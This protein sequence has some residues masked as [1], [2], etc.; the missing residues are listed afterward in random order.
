MPL[1][2]DV[3]VHPEHSAGPLSYEIE[4]SW[5][6]RFGFALAR[7]GRSVL[8]QVHTHA[9]EAFHSLTDDRWPIV[10]TPGFLSLVL[11]HFALHRL[12][13]RSMYL[14][15]IEADGRFVE[16]PVDSRIRFEA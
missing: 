14:A 2:V 15:E 7:D 10:T 9:G 3:A 6:N 1:V 16:V 12:D 8:V 13:H 5:L 4:Q 11:P